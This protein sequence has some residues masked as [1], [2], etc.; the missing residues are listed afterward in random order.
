MSESAKEFCTW[1]KDGL[2][3][4]VLEDAVSPILGI[5]IGA[6]WNM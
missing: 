5:D 6:P 4:E 3:S 1:R 2:R